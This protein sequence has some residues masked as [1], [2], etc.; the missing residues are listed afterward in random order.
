MAGEKR[1]QFYAEMC[2]SLDAGRGRL[3]GLFLCQLRL[4]LRLARTLRGP[5]GVRVFGGNFRLEAIDFVDNLLVF[6]QQLGELF[7]PQACVGLICWRW[8]LFEC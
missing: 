1:A 6:L 3:A 8:A 7:L 2:S 4:L 5:L